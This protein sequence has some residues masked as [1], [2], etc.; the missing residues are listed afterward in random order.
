MVGPLLVSLLGSRHQMGWFMTSQLLSETLLGHFHNLIGLLSGFITAE[1]NAD[2]DQSAQRHRTAIAMPGVQCV[3][4]QR[5]LCMCVANPLRTKAPQ[6]VTL[7]GFNIDDLTQGG[8]V[9]NKVRL[10]SELG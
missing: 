6:Y 9:F 10:V 4:L 5:I 3:Q 1:K 2:T 7:L 8:T